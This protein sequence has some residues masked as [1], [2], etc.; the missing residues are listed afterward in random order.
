[1]QQKSLADA[2]LVT[3][4]AG[5]FTMFPWEGNKSKHAYL[6]VNIPVK[7]SAELASKLPI[8]SPPAL[9]RS[10]WFNGGDTSVAIASVEEIQLL[11]DGVQLDDLLMTDVWFSDQ[12]LHLMRAHPLDV[13]SLDAGWYEE[14]SPSTSQIVQLLRCAPLLEHAELWHD[15][16]KPNA[17]VIE[18]GLEHLKSLEV[19]FV[20]DSGYGNLVISNLPMLASVR[21]DGNHTNHRFS[22]DIQNC[23]LLES[24]EVSGVD[25][26]RKF[27]KSIASLP[28]LRRLKIVDAF[29]DS[30]PNLELASN[31]RNLQSL[32][33]DRCDVCQ[34]LANS[35]RDLDLPN[36]SLGNLYTPD[37][38]G[39]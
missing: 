2:K 25:P 4:A 15:S 38:I 26:N 30:P 23:P 17:L 37:Q 14:G 18:N 9:R 19:E 35:L 31:L 16:L 27:W 22:M 28:H 11:F 24:V 6:E 7:W 21:L 34:Q 3:E 1:M 12:A 33:I 36:K 39:E 20:F 10:V 29:C 8:A 5:I 13:R 32:T